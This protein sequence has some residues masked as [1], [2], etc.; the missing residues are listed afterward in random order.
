MWST[1]EG[2]GKPL[3]YSCLE[4]PMNGMKRQKDRT[5]KD[6]L[7]RSGEQW[8]NNSRKNEEMEPKQKQCQAVDVIG[9]KSK[10]R[11]FKE[12][13]CI[14]TWNV[15]STNQSK[16]SS[17]QFSSVTQSCPTLCDPMNCSMPGLPVHHQLLEFTQIHVHRVS[18]A[19]QPSHPLSSPSPPA[20]PFSSCPQSL[21]ASESFPMSQLF[22]WGGQS[23]G[24]SALASFLTKK[25]QGWSQN[26]LV[27]PDVFFFF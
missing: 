6:E 5:L 3:Q 1:G 2:N 10:V 22:A 19:I 8:R 21:P 13:Y 12:Q 9:D 20:P 11:C 18:D 4:N 7:S 14:G 26:A 25:S 15:K 27:F 16:F 24:V 17:L 23:T